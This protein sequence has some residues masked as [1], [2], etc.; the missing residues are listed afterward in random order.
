MQ[1]VSLI[2]QTEHQLVLVTHSKN[3]ET[4]KRQTSLSIA[5][6]V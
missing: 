6:F 1:T 2:I 3:I 4:K 5:F